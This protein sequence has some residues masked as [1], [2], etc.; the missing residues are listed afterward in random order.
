[1]GEIYK[2]PKKK[3]GEGCLLLILDKNFIL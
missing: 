2:E 3:G 1:V